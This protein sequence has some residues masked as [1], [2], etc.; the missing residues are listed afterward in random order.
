MKNCIKIDEA[1]GHLQTLGFECGII[2]GEEHR[3]I[4]GKVHGLSFRIYFF[5]QQPLNSEQYRNYQFEAGIGIG[6]HVNLN[7]LA[8]LCNEFNCSYRFL[9]AIISIG[10]SDY[11]GLQMDCETGSEPIDKFQLDTEFFM[12]GITLFIDDIAK[13]RLIPD[14]QTSA[15]H[16]SA[17]QELYGA[18]PDP[19][20]A[21]LNYRSAAHEG[22]AGSQNNLGDL[23]ETGHLVPKSEVYAAYWYSRAAERGEPTAYLSLAML[24]SKSTDPQV[25]IDAAKFAFL[26]QSQ[27]REGKNRQ[28]AVQCLN[29]LEQTLSKSDLELAEKLSELW[30]PLYRERRRLSDTLG[31]ISNAAIAI[32][33]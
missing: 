9:K 13:S 12:H 7:H 4:E 1:A 30:L 29:E 16:S 6:K 10:N 19:D 31:S 33:H 14:D 28:A 32:R 5:R 18:S 25:R 8:L 21:I 26:A 3:Y 11:V 22:F 20:S 2:S 17:L 15:M 24:L 27:L 23:Y